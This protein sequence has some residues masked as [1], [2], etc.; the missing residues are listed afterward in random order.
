MVE[1]K[2][3]LCRSARC[4]SLSRAI[5]LIAIAVTFG[6]ASRTG[7]FETLGFA[8]DD[9]TVDY[10]INPNFPE[11]EVG[12][13]SHQIDLLR[14]AA[15]AW[16]N[17][18]RAD[19]A[20][21]LRG[22]TERAVV[23]LRDGRNVVFWADTDGGDALAAT[24][25][26]PTRT[27]GLAWDMV[28]FSQ[29]FGNDN[30]WV[31]HGEPSGVGLDLLGVATHEFGHALG[32]DHTNVQ[33]AT[34]AA[35]IIGRGLPL[36]TLEEDDRAG[37][38]SVYAP[39]PEAPAPVVEFSAVS[40]DFGPTA[41]GNEVVLQ[42]NNFTFLADTQLVVGGLA[43]DASRF[44]I[45]TPKRLVIAEMPPGI[46]GPVDIA[47]VNSIGMASLAQSY[48]YTGTEFVRGDLNGQTGVDL[49]DASFLLNFLFLHGPRPVDCLDSA[50]SDD[51]GE[52]TLSDAVF[53]LN[54]LFR[55]GNVIAPP[56]P[57]AGS[58]PTL[59]ALDC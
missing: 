46:V 51:D 57:A 49:S 17:Q 18:T 53:L 58:D 20:F 52:L 55:R 45:E 2:S 14:G 59:D 48:T 47:V 1:G 13:R 19:F 33:A 5:F 43:V 38:E 11:E 9:G 25:V 54:F 30:F 35:V 41:G 56:H 32:L 4:G 22:T 40:P 27:G 7:G 6:F 10:W 24:V 16:T 44:R 29:T 15:D 42:G 23:N 50:D 34:M 12:E 36:R 37:A 21:R 39:L 26:G 3:A 31:G 8:W 28:F